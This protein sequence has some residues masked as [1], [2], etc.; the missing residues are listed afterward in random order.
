MMLIACAKTIGHIEG[1][2]VRPFQV[3]L[4]VG[5]AMEEAR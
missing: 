4:K 2:K 1:G 5:F 3:T